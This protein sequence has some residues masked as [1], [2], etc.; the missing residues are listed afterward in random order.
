MIFGGVL[1]VALALGGLFS[2]TVTRRLTRLRRRAEELVHNAAAFPAGTADDGMINSDTPPS[3]VVLPVQGSS[4]HGAGT[5]KLRFLS[6]TGDEIH[7]LSR[8]FQFMER[9][10][11]T[12]VESLQEAQH[13]LSAQKRLLTT[14]LDVNPDLISLVDVNM[15]YQTGNLAFAQSVGR[16]V[17]DLQGVNGYE[18]FSRETAERRVREGREVLVGPALRSAGALRRRPEMVPVVQ[19]PCAMRRGRPWFY[20]WIRTSRKSRSMNSSSFRPRKWNPSANWPE[21]WPT[22]STRRWVSFWVMRSFG[23]GRAARKQPCG[24]S[25]HHRTPSQ[26]CRKIVADLLGFSRQTESEKCEMCFNNSVMEAVSLVRHAFALDRVRIV[27]RLD[28]S[29]PIIYGD[30]RNSTGLAQS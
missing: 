24:G 2:R 6:A 5:D 26:V 28:D 23:R 12:Y 27:T 19:I 21:A 7:D 8:T 3:S 20:A 4:D 13:K 22:R 18:L 14:V 25:G 30:P 11:R 1:F 10:L 17:P 29:Y 15:V 9:N 16:T